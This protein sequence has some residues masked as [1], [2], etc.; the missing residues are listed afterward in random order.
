MLW[1]SK[2]FW[3][4][5]TIVKSLLIST[6]DKVI[7]YKETFYR[8]QLKPQFTTQN[9]YETSWKKI[10]PLAL[11][12]HASSSTKMSMFFHAYSQ[13]VWIIRVINYLS[14]SRNESLINVESQG[15]FSGM[16]RMGRERLFCFFAEAVHT[17]VARWFIFKP[18]IQI[19]VY[20]GVP[21][22]VVCCYIL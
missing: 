6:Q 10:C 5:K 11:F 21:W 1:S 13:T 20:F 17:R 4:K 15:T 16:N 7:Y 8:A 22:N 18:K 2:H 9:R 12:Q 19:C 3:Q 14:P